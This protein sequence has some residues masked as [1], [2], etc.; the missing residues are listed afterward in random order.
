MNDEPTPDTVPAAELRA[1]TERSC[2]PMTGTTVIGPNS[3]EDRAESAASNSARAAS[4]W[5]TDEEEVRSS[6]PSWDRT[7]WRAASPFWSWW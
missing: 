6:G 7:C 3:G 2:R 5:A 1:R 4:S